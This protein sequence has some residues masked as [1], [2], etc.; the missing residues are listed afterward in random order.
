MERKFKFIY[1]M[2]REQGVVEN[3]RISNQTFLNFLMEIEKLYNK[4]KNPFHNFDHGITGS[5]F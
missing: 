4:Y 3:Y 1:A 5:L 2:F